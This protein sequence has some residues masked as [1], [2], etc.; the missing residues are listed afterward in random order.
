MH[1]PQRRLVVGCTLTEVG[2]AED[3]AV[4]RSSGDPAR[5]AQVA[6]RLTRDAHEPVVVDGK[7]VR[8]AYT[9][10]IV[11]EDPPDAGVLAPIPADGGAP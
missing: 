5:D 1:E 2:R 11:L 6:D 4:L 10:N 7:P 9:F 8:V 3:C